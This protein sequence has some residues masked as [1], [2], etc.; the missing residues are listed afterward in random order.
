MYYVK[1]LKEVVSPI[2]AVPLLALSLPGEKFKNCGKKKFEKSGMQTCFGASSDIMQWRPVEGPLWRQ[3]S[4]ELGLA[5]LPG[6]R[7]AKMLETRRERSTDGTSSRFTWVVVE[8]QH[9]HKTAGG[10]RREAAG[11]D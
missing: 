4:T 3:E 5:G 8:G 6:G 2:K 9:S 11:F 7:K 1:Q 10:Q